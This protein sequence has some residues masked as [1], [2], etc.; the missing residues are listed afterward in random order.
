MSLEYYLF[1]RQKYE[2]IISN[3]DYIIESHEFINNFTSTENHPDY[4][5]YKLLQHN[6]NNIFLFNIKAETI[7]LANLCTININ[8]L[9]AHEFECDTIDISPEKSMN[10][11][12]CNRCG[13]TKT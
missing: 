7:K 3:L 9:C 5:P 1:C 6:D 10:I 4:I 8:R 11:K 13:Y 2:D 12:Y